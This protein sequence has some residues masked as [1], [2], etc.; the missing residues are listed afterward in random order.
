MDLFVALITV[1]I[2]VAIVRRVMSESRPE[3]PRIQPSLP[4]S[5][6]RDAA[7]HIIDKAT[8]DRMRQAFD[9]INNTLPFLGGQESWDLG[10]PPPVATLEEADSPNT[11]SLSPEDLAALHPPS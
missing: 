1:S 6:V 11:Q 5:A 3:R 2:I 7:G 10:P 8:D 9:G 4:A